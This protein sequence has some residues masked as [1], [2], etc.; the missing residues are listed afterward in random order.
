MSAPVAESMEL[1]GGVVCESS[2]SCFPNPSAKVLIPFFLNF[3]LTAFLFRLF[4]LNDNE[5]LVLDLSRVA[6]QTFAIWILIA[7][8]HSGSLSTGLTAFTNCNKLTL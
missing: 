2:S 6:L 5:G 4:R 7:R 3:A 8:S 1:A